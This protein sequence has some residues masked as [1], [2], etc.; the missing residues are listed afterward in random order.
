MV[1]RHRRWNDRL[2]DWRKER[3][4]HQVQH[5]HQHS[6]WV[7][8]RGVT[9]KILPNCPNWA[10]PHL[11]HPRLIPDF[12]PGISQ[13]SPYYMS[14]WILNMND[15]QLSSLQMI[16]H[17]NK[18]PRHQTKLAIIIIKYFQMHTMLDIQVIPIFGHVKCPSPWKWAIG[19]V[20]LPSQCNFKIHELKWATSGKTGTND[21]KNGFTQIWEMLCL[22]LTPVS[23]QVTGRSQV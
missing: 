10:P 23:N 13:V 8:K 5:F 16:L 18:N 7:N 17:H 6:K 4:L 2:L 21:L 14:L 1:L 19:N 12:S 3:S 22:F 11:K 20:P 15:S 9:S